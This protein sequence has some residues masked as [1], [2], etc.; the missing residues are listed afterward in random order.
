M[1]KTLILRWNGAR[2]VHVASPN[3]GSGN[4]LDGV[5]ASSS[6]NA[7]AVGTFNGPT[8]RQALAIHCC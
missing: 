1:H 8:T 6:A 5:A 2:W 3:P 7:W 4:D